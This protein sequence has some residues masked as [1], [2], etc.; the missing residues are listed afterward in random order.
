METKLKSKHFNF[1][2]DFEHHEIPNHI[3]RA[4]VDRGNTLD[5]QKAGESFESKQPFIESFIKKKNGSLVW[6]GPFMTFTE[7]GLDLEIW[8]NGKKVCQKRYVFDAECSKDYDLWKQKNNGL[9][10]AIGDY[11]TG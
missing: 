11:P 4:G 3:I 5:K 9:A 7:Y 10:S 6:D 1:P 8:K 2:F